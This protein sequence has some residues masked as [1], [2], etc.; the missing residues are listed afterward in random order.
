MAME[1][2]ISPPKGEMMPM[3]EEH[4]HRVIGIHDE[5]IHEQKAEIA[6]LKMTI[7]KLRLKLESRKYHGST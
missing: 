4:F 1:E 7:N 2:V 3:T 6:K 5:L